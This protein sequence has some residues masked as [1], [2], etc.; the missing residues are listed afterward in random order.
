HQHP[1][2]SYALSMGGVL[3]DNGEEEARG[4]R[5]L[6]RQIQALPVEQQNLF[7]NM[8]VYPAMTVQTNK[9]I[10]ENNDVDF[11]FSPESK[12]K[13]LQ[14]LEV[15]K[16]STPLFGRQ[17][18]FST[19][20]PTLSLAALRHQGHAKSRLIRNPLPP[21]DLPRRRRR[22]VVAMRETTLPR[23]MLELNPIGP[24]IV[25]GLTRYGWQAEF[26]G[27]KFVNPETQAIA[28]LE[29][30]LQ[31]DAE[32]LILDGMLPMNIQSHMI[33]RLKQA[34]PAI[35][36]ALL[37]TDAWSL[38][39]RFIRE[40][41]AW[42]DVL[43]TQDSPALPIWQEPEV[44]RKVLQSFVPIGNQ[45]G[46]ADHPLLPQ[47]LFSGDMRTSWIRLLWI[48]VADERLALPIKKKIC[49]HAG[50]GLPALESFELYMRGLMEGTCCLSFSLR[51]DD[52]SFIITGRCP[53]TLRSGSLL[54]QEATAN[55]DYFFLSGEHYL[56]F[57]TL[58]ELQAIARF[59]AEHPDEAETVRR[60]GFAF[61]R[62]QYSED[63][64]V[65]YLDHVCFFAQHGSG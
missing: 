65:G 22:V 28:L 57:S 10:H 2:I 27:M 63:K 4:M 51:V 33:A 48:L 32:L 43:W 58:A 5:H 47:M 12:K 19:P 7:Y 39:P 1:L 40:C 42:F 36:V 34:Q 14:L 3:F 24:R 29:R 20:V 25:S 15:L 21:A 23:V 17:L 9:I 18:D 11:I 8:L 49:T 62:E 26:F 13:L 35:R 46:S 38:K 16:A 44:A 37:F 60:R 52:Q 55:L 53:E 59:I 41:A 6:A 31:L 30:C 56:E 54:V 50:D 45:V 61:A 64:L